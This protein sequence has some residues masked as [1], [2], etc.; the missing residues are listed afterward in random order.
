MRLHLHRRCLSVNAYDWVTV[1]SKHLTPYSLSWKPPKLRRSC[2]R[3]WFLTDSILITV[4]VFFSFFVCFLAGIGT[5]PIA[6]I[7]MRENQAFIFHVFLSS[8]ISSW[9]FFNFPLSFNFALRTAATCFFFFLFFI[10]IGYYIW[11]SYLDSGVGL[12]VRIP[13]YFMNFIFQNITWTDTNC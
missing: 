4:C 13:K 8:Q 2:T 1:P 11:S 3:F 6:P 7:I 5:I 9:Y 10:I 12:C